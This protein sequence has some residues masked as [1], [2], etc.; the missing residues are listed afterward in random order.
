MPPEAAGTQEPSQHWVGRSVPCLG[1]PHSVGQRKAASR[2]GSGKERFEVSTECPQPG[3]HGVKGKSA[4][5]PLRSAMGRE[6]SPVCLQKGELF[7]YDSPQPR[8]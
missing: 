6:G 5:I 3:F 2:G 1:G 8:G 4:V 7:F